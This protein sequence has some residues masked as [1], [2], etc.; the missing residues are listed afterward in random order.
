M[1]RLA[2]P[3]LAAALAA[4]AWVSTPAGVDSRPPVALRPG[5]V[6]VPAGAVRLG[7]PDGEPGHDADESPPTDV[8]VPAFAIDATEVTVDAFEA[9]KVEVGKREPL[10]RWWT[11]AEKPAGWP[12]ACNL[13]SA[14]RDHPANCVDFLAART[15]CQLDGGDLPTEAEWERSARADPAAGVYPWGPAFDPGRAVSS[16][17]CGTRGC[18][19]GTEPVARR[20]LRCNALGICD[21]AGNVWEWTATGYRERLGAYVADVP[22]ESPE[23]PVHRG[24]SWLNHRPELFRAAQRGLAYPEHGLTGVGFRCVRRA[25][26]RSR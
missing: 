8:F 13:G 18:R 14:R 21:L 6:L 26:E 10:A 5:E 20:G 23:K 24:G 17:P 3:V 15:Y 25:V 11:E 7:S 2:L 19:G 9:R 22:A 4:P 12:G 1:R 16:V